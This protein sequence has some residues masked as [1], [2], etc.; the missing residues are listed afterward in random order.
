MEIANKLLI[1]FWLLSG[2]ISFLYC[3]KEDKMLLRIKNYD[4]YNFIDLIIFF[5]ICLLCG[6][7]VGISNKLQL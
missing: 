3:C 4:I 7:I 1:I 6:P 2:I 5:V